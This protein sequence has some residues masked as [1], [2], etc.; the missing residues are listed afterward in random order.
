MMRVP[1]VT[2]QPEEERPKLLVRK[3]TTMVRSGTI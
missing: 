2:H 3:Y 1:G